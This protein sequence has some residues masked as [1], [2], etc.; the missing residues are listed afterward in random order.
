[1]SRRR[2][3]LFRLLAATLVPAVFVCLL[4]GALWLFG[5]GHS[6]A[7]FIKL[8]GR[9]AYTTNP[10]FGW[11]FFPP[12]IAREPTVCEIPAVKA[13]G[14]CRIFILGESA[15]WG[16]PESAFNFGRMLEAMLRQRYPG[17]RFEVV[18]AAMTA[19]NSNCLVPIAQQCRRMPTT[20]SR[21]ECDF[22]HAV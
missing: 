19:I 17:V 8:K 21:L 18:N 22:T 9:N 20:D 5:Y 7:F 4:E 2:L 15:A 13:E 6:T 11:Q 3:W 12:A 14:T 1:M 10:C 16:T